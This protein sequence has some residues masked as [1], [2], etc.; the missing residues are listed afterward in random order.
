MTGTDPVA[1]G[2]DPA[3]DPEEIAM[4]STTLTIEG[5][6]TAD[7]EL[8]FTSQGKAVVDGR[9]LAN[10]RRQAESGEW[11]GTEPTA[12]NFV[13]FGSAAE[14]LVESARRGTRLVLVGKLRTEVWADK[15]TGEKRTGQKL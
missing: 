5:N 1:T 7:P 11:E 14:N 4:F 15:A 12:V 3:Q 9:V 10:E 8:R 13:L 2:T 6:L